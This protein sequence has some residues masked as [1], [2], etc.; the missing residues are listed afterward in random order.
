MAQ[1]FAV[2]MVMR[3]VPVRVHSTGAELGFGTGGTCCCDAPAV[4]QHCAQHPCKATPAKAFAA[5]L[6]KEICWAGKSE[7]CLG[8]KEERARGSLSFPKAGKRDMT[9]EKWIETRPVVL[10]KRPKQTI[11]TSVKNQ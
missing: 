11:V 2:C 4:P 1:A 8:W 3:C 6:V 5:A 10:C 7:G 9:Q